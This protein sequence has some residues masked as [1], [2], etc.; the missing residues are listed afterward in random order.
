L[1]LERQYISVAFGFIHRV[2]LVIEAICRPWLLDSCCSK[3]RF[4]A[5]VILL[6]CSASILLIISS[7]Q[8]QRR[9]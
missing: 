2:W 8:I 6:F 7:Q 5:V 9:N 1:S 4:F 3:T